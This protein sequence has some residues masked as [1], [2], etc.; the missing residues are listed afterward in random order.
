MTKNS[1]L[2]IIYQLLLACVFSFLVHNLFSQTY[3]GGFSQ[4]QVTAGLVK[5]TSMAFSP[6]G[7]IF[8]TLQGGQCRVIQNGTLLATPFISL[9]VNM[10][11]ERGL[12]GIAFDPN[13]STNNY[14]Y[15]YYT[16]STAVN[17]RISRFTANGNVV[18]P[19]SEVVLLDLDS[20]GSVDYHNGGCMKFG[21]DGKFM[22][23][24]ETMVIVPMLRI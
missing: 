10:S 21:P 16:L 7:R 2:K 11:G 6:D 13:F 22:L 24:L 19:G 20:I 15:L 18:V 17:N 4:Q 8:V 23:V 5:P 3:P 9:S 14:I 12:L 1:Q